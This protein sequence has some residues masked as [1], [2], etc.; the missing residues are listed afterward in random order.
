[1]AGRL[2]VGRRN[3]TFQH[4]ET[5]LSNRKKRQRA[6]EFLVQGVRPI[7][8][9]A[10]TGWPLVSVLRQE[11]RRLSEWARGI[12]G[13][14]SAPVV[15]VAPELIAEL[16]ERPEEPPELVLVAAMAAD[17]LGRIEVGPDFLGA[18]FD[19]PANPGNVGALIRSADA[20]GV[21]GVVVTGHA[22][23]VYDP[24]AV[25]ASTGSL[26]AV[27]TV[28]AASHTQVLDWVRGH[29]GVRIVGTDEAGEV[30]LAGHDLTGPTLLLVGNE[31]AGLSQAWREACDVLVRIPM[32]GTASSLNA[33]NAATVAFYEAKVQRSGGRS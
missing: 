7:T 25:R 27:P 24:Q 19:R 15:D 26:F 2:H 16:G 13:E 33:A 23:D 5:L 28:R 10:R 14:V 30:E 29:P 31:T 1:M 21:G 18:V 4:W 12:L 6:G 22:V 11:G 32:G 20:F 3:A 8:L 9:A 17:D